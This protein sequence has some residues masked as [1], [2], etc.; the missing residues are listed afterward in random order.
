MPLKFVLFIIALCC[1]SFSVRAAE[2]AVTDAAV[3][4]G[5]SPFNWIIRDD[6]ISSSIGGASLVVKFTGTRQVVLKVDLSAFPG[7]EASSFPILAWQVSGGELKTHQVAADE[8]TVLLAREVADPQIELF[9]KGISPWEDRWTG[10]VAP[11]S[12][13]ITGFIVDEG[14]KAKTVP[15]AE[16]VWLNIGDSILAGDA[17]AYAEGQGR[18]KRDEWAASDDAR[19]SYG[20][21]LARH[22]G[23]RESRIAFGGYNWGGGLGKVPD[24]ATVIE[25]RLRTASPE[26]ALVNLGTNGKP[27]DEQVFTALKKLRER[28]GTKTKILVMIPVSGA[29]RA[30]VTRAYKTWQTTTPDANAHLIDLG[31]VSFATADKVHPTAAGHQSIF[32]AVLPEVEKVLGGSAKS[33]T[34]LAP[35]PLPKRK[36]TPGKPN[37]LVIVT[38]QQFAE[39]MS[40]RMGREHIHTPA[41]DS[42]AAQGTSFTRAYCIFPLC[43]PSRNSMFTGLY[44][45]HV[46]WKPIHDD[47][48]IYLGRY[49]L[50]AGYD[51]AYSGKSELRGKE[52]ALHGFQSIL[53][54]Q[55]GPTRIEAIRNGGWDVWAASEAVRFITQPRDKPF[56][57]VASFLNPHNICEWSRRL[58]GQKQDLDCG[59]IGEPPPVEKLPPAPANLGPQRDEPDGMTLMRRSYQASSLFPVGGYTTDDWRRHRW[60]YYRMVELVDKEIGRLLTALREAGIEDNTMILFTSDHGECAG[61]HDWNQKSMPYDESTRVPFIVSWKGHTRPGTSDLLVNTGIDLVPTVLAAGGVAIPAHLPGSS[62]LDIALGKPAATWREEVISQMSMSQGAEVDGIKPTLKWWMLRTDRYKYCLFSKGE[63]RESLVDMQ[64]DPG[65]MQNLAADPAHRAILLDHRERLA[66]YGREHQD[67]GV[68]L[69]LAHDV[70]PVPFTSKPSPAKAAKER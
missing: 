21:L 68:A 10:N 27:T 35:A 20:W 48:S 7:K 67:K 17:A 26:V 34:A 46:R 36:P 33:T 53:A 5:L 52:I 70:A 23:H 63:R 37:V 15:Q 32:H 16:K 14:A 38:D 51:T 69:S 22:F 4:S 58:A 12:V 44:P 31:K 40:C 3:R 24:L 56:L 18:P 65:E 41:L 64:A 62:V 39:V 49:L 47:P 8:S 61:A 45:Q 11:N 42:L 66:R 50:D 59:E 6:S 43:G 2:V 28:C 9:I 30:E 1:A 13:K 57:I 19:A 54:P 60:G 55:G 29:A 25:Q